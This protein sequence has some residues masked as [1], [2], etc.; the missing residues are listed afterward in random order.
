M[1]NEVTKNLNKQLTE[2]KVKAGKEKAAIVKEYKAEIKSWRKDLGEERKQTIKLEK[3]IEELSKEELTVHV[4]NDE[5]FSD[6]DSIESTSEKLKNHEEAPVGCI[7]SPQCIIRQPLPPSSPSM[8][9]LRNQDSK[10]HEHMMS[11]AGVP[12][13]Y[14][15]CE[16]CMREYYSKNY[17]CDDCVWLKWH[18]ELHGYPDINPWDFKKY[19]QSSELE[20]WGLR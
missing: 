19:L 11:N 9:F 20:M 16:R 4:D 13:K 14:G 5:A 7:H 8:P 17:G 18:G 15:G 10:Y 2:S 1:K 3:K 12:G 6:E